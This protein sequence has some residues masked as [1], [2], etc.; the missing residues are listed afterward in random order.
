MYRLR[1][2]ALASAISR[3]K[4]ILGFEVTIGRLNKLTRRKFHVIQ[5]G[6]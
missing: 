3:L 5:A 4:I 2:V 6:K 1:P